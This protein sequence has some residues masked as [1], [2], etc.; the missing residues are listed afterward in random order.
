MTKLTAVNIC[1]DSIGENGITTLLNMGIDATKI[2]NILDE[3]TAYTQDKGWTWNREWHTLTPDTSGFIN[4]PSNILRANTYG[5]SRQTPAI[6][7]GLRMYDQIN[8]TYVWLLPL[9]LQMYISLPFD[10]LPAGVKNYITYSAATIAQNRLLG[11]DAVDAKLEKKAADAWN[12]MIRDDIFEAGYNMLSGSN[13]VRGVLNRGN[14]NR[15]GL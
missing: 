12:S 2:S 7:R 1:L 10:Q 13:S 14:F 15:G 11:S 6:Q 8:N 9:S 3:H 4:L 5:V